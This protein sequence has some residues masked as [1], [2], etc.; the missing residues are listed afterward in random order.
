MSLADPLCC[1]SGDDLALGVW[2]LAFWFRYKHL[3]NYSAKIS[4][5]SNTTKVTDQNFE[6]VLWRLLIAAAGPRWL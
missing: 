2:Y 4:T 5:F 1:G 6:S 3:E